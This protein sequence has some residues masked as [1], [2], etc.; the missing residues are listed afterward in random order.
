MTFTEGFDAFVYAISLAL[1]LLW[2]FFIVTPG[3][4]L[5]L[6]NREQREFILALVRS[7]K[8]DPRSESTASKQTV[9]SVVP[10]KA[11]S[12]IQSPNP[13]QIYP[14]LQDLVEDLWAK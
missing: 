14:T 4:I 1:F 8:G 10:P 2:F 13:K 6:S 3:V 7:I 9:K 11:D 12:K 5:L